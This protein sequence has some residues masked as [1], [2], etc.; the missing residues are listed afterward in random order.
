MQREAEGG[1]P[2]L[3]P[4]FVVLSVGVALGLAAVLDD[5][6]L[7]WLFT[8]ERGRPFSPAQLRW[9][10]HDLPLAVGAAGVLMA[11]LIP[12][13]RALRRRTLLDAVALLAVGALGL[14]ALGGSLQVWSERRLNP[15]LTRR[16]PNPRRASEAFLPDQW[17]ALARLPWGAA[18]S[19]PLRP[20]GVGLRDHPGVIP[21]DPFLL[22]RLTF[23][24]MT[25]PQVEAVL[26]PV[27]T[28]T[29]P[30]P[31]GFG[32]LYYSM[33]P[34]PRGMRDADLDLYFGYAESGEPVVAVE[35]LNF[36]RYTF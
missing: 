28:P 9:W 19:G 31:L 8:A 21:F 7:A 10:L 26:G 11:T 27:A 33:F 13:L 14:A 5:S 15:P 20:K 2:R 3:Q 17:W 12:V 18:S 30:R 25:Q 36:T 35:S 1:F 32:H 23:V 16:L 6:S 29:T 24:G 34:C 22:Q 4:L